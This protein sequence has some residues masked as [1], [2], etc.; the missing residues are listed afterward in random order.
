VKKLVAE[1]QIAPEDEVVGIL[2][3]HMLKD[4]DAIVSYHMHDVDGA[5]RP[6][7]NRPITIPADVTA[8]ERV[9]HG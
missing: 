7:A 4:A 6:G 1:G 3:G 2:T 9:L 8:L 5:P